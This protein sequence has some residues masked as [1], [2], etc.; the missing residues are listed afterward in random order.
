MKIP[1]GRGYRR[2]IG[3][4]AL[5]A[6]IAAGGVVAFAFFTAAG[7]GTGNGAVG[8]STAWHVSSSAYTGGP[9]Y[10]GSGSENVPFTVTNQNPGNQA[11]TSITSALTTDGSGGI[12]DVNTSSFNDACLASWFTVSNTTPTFPDDLAGTAPGPAGSYSGTATLTMQDFP[13]SQN[14]CQGV[15]PQVTIT[16]N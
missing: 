8:T 5:A 15:D 11:L 16:V 4:A 9:L 10:P 2:K 12:Y 7:T 3:L 1:A 6:V 13:T 14:A